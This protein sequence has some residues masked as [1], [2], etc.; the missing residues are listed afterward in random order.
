MT[1]L[2]DPTSVEDDQGTCPGGG[3]CDSAYCD[4]RR[5]FQVT[6]MVFYDVT[7]KAH[8]EDEATELGHTVHLPDG[9]VEFEQEDLWEGDEGSRVP[10]PRQLGRQRPQEEAFL[11]LSAP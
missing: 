6:F 7:V 1:D 10:G 9:D 2:T 11:A 3:E 8:S 4:D 5:D